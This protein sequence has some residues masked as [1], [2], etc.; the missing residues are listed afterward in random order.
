MGDV[1]TT[2]VLPQ[3]DWTRTLLTPLRAPDW[4]AYLYFVLNS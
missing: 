3:T 2:V 1:T 4:R